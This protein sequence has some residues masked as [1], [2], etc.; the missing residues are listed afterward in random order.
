M[1]FPTRFLSHVFALIAGLLKRLLHSHKDPWVLVHVIIIGE[2]KFMLVRLEFVLKRIFHPVNYYVRS[3][4][5][6]VI[7]V[8]RL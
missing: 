6:R 8:L 2:D 1:S 5:Q 4:M 7:F 3:L